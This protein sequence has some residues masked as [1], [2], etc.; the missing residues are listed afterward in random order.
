MSRFDLDTLVRGR[1][2]S[3]ERVEEM[4]VTYNSP[5]GWV[6]GRNDDNRGRIMYEP[7]F[8]AAPRPL[9]LRPKV[10]DERRPK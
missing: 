6:A 10:A 8:V 9:H 1:V 7:E 2:G 4:R 3:G 5:F